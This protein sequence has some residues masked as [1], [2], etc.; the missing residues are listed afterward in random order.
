MLTAVSMCDAQPGFSSTCFLPVLP[1]RLVHALLA[2]RRA[3]PA[4]LE[5]DA[6]LAAVRAPVQHVPLHIGLHHPHHRVRE[7]VLCWC[8]CE[9]SL[10][11]FQASFLDGVPSLWLDHPVSGSPRSLFLSPYSRGLAR[12]KSVQLT[13]SVPLQVLL[14]VLHRRAAAGDQRCRTG[15]LSVS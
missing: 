12:A 15:V 1:D 8:L 5:G 3:A 13:N 10:I 2:A 11:V 7:P 14:F 6:G 9:S 4:A